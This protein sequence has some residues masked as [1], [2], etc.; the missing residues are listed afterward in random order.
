MTVLPLLLF[1]TGARGLSFAIIGVL[2]FVAPTL[3][4]IV[5]LV[6]GEPFS[7]AYLATFIFIW[8]GL[9]VFVFELLHFERKQK[10]AG[11]RPA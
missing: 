2:Q 9:A 11:M 3:Q 10:R 4:F 8:S 7:L 5:G 1:L 6:Y